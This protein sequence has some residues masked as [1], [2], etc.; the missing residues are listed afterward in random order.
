MQAQAWLKGGLMRKPPVTIA[1][2]RAKYESYLIAVARR[3][4]ARRYSIAL[5]TFFSHFKDRKRPDELYGSDIED[6]KV[7]R[8]KD[9]VKERTI[10]YEIGVIRAF[11]NWLINTH[12][13]PTFN[14]AARV[15]RLREPENP[16][17]ALSRDE[18][19]ALVAASSKNPKETLLVRLAL[20][21]GLR[22]SEL[23]ALSWSW[24]DFEQGM[25]YLPAD[26]VKNWHGR[27]IPVRPDVLE[28]LRFNAPKPGK[29]GLVFK[30]WAETPEAIHRRWKMISKRAGVLTPGPHQARR[31]FA[32]YMHRAGADLR[33]IQELLG[34]R[35]IKTTAVYLSPADTVET[36]KL[37]YSLP[38]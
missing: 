7:I 17:R 6:Y 19:E 22:R 2:W 31:A 25:I 12:D 8:K 14:P 33:T 27:E 3:S 4:T 9:A 34:H 1:Q 24:I 23:S 35:D 20:T 11:Y 15:K 36:R 5:E 38:L 21:T 26:A 28:L 13:V 30:G 16:R 18:I 32:T 29:D 10:N 37:L